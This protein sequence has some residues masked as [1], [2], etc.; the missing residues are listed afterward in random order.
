GQGL[1]AVGA[2][3]Q[4][5]GAGL[6]AVGA[7]GLFVAD[8]AALAVRAL[9]AADVAAAFDGL[10]TAKHDVMLV[11]LDDFGGVYKLPKAVTHGDLTALTDEAFAALVRDGKISHGAIVFHEVV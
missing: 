10:G 5:V 4:A 7:G 6:Q 3:L 1:Q 2:G 8:V 9:P 11:V